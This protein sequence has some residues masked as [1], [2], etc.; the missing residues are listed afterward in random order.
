MLKART[1][2]QT[3]GWKKPFIELRV[4]I[5][6]D[7]LKKFITWCCSSWV[8]AHFYSQSLILN[9]FISPESAFILRF[10]RTKEVVWVKISCGW[11]V[12]IF[13]VWSLLYPNLL[14]PGR[15]FQNPLSLDIPN[16]S[17][18]KI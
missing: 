16:D 1:D 5:K 8:H 12:M 10:N 7:F 18:S 14:L 6:D 2:G 15:D 13:Y 9:C 3:D 11:M 17:V 4:R